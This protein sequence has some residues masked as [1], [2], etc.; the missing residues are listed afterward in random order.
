[1]AFPVHRVAVLALD[2][3]IPLDFAIPVQLFGG[4]GDSRY[5]VR[6]CAPKP[7]VRTTVGFGITADAGLRGLARADT[8]VVP[9]FAPHDVPVDP[10]VLAA[11]RRANARGARLVSIC[12][13]AFALAQA[14]LLDGR[15]ATTHWEYTAEL[16]RDHPGVLVRPD[17]LYV[18]DG[19]ILTSAGVSAGMD[20]C[21]HIIRA[22]HGVAEARRVARNVVAAPHR[23]GNQAQYVDRPVHADEAGVFAAVCAWITRNLDADISLA[24]MARQAAMSPRTLSRR[25][26]QSTGVTPMQ[27][28]LAARMDEARRLLESGPL[29]VDEI[30]TRCGFG[31]ALNLRT[32][33]RRRLDTTPTAYRR[34]FHHQRRDPG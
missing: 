28:V 29:S 26:N 7:Q 2:R 18:D 1:M 27:W 11:L 20:L 21:L 6:V 24:T 25:F 17:V 22:D 8:V 14:G 16:S 5:Q 34:A 33:F 31:T 4:N 13:G 10:A 23:D 15:P 19:D 3:L 9:G 12:T 30:A 32:H